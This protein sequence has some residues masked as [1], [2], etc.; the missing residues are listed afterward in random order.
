MTWRSYGGLMALA[1]RLSCE[2]FSF[3]IEWK[4]YS[5]MALAW[6]L[7]GAP[8]YGF[9]YD[10]IFATLKRIFFS[11]ALAW[12]PLW[13][14]FLNIRMETFFFHGAFSWHG[15]PMAPPWCSLFG[16]ISST[17]DWNLFS[18]IWR[19]R[20]APCGRVSFALE[21]EPHFHHGALLWHGAPMAPFLWNFSSTLDWIKF[22]PWFS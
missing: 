22:P 3:R 9:P 2:G 13:K 7:H 6:C 15:A 4:F 1:W 16:S 12:R 20:G 5:D 8:T 21:M 19:L 10:L 14:S 17:L 18:C 11:M